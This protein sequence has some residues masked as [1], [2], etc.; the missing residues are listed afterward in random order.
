MRTKTRDQSQKLETV[1]EAKAVMNILDV[2]VGKRHIQILN[3][4]VRPYG[5]RYTG[6]W[7]APKDIH[8]EQHQSLL[9]EQ[10]IVGIAGYVQPCP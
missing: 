8:K 7:S 2:L 1:Q 3:D 5:G 9:P 6:A 10:A 4:K